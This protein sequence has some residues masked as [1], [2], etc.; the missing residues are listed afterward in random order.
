MAEP[1]TIMVID[2]D[3]AFRRL[4]QIALEAHGYRVV[5]APGGE[6]GLAL[7]DESRPDLVI[8]DVMMGWVLEGVSLSRQMMERAELRDIPIIMCTSIRSSDYLGFFPQDEYLHID[9]WLDKPCA[10]GDLIAEV[11]ATRDRHARYAAQ[12]A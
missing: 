8:L 3:P 1:Y 9:S 12:K 4:T 2:D 5:I 6:E 11:E 7:M 10:P